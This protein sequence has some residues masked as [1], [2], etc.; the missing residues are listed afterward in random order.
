MSSLAEDLKRDVVRREIF[1]DAVPDYAKLRG[2]EIGALCSP[3]LKKCETEVFYYDVLPKEELLAQFGSSYQGRTFVDV[4][5]VAGTQ[6]LSAVLGEEKFDYFVA[7]HVIEHIPDFIGFFRAAFESLNPGGKF[8]LAMPDRRFTFDK[9]RPETSAGHLILDHENHGTVDAA[10]HFLDALIYHEAQPPVYWR[11]ME[12]LRYHFV[13]HHH[14]FNGKNFLDLVIRPLIRLGYFPFSVIRCETRPELY[15]EFVIVLE[16][17]D[18]SEGVSVLGE[19]IAVQPPAAVTPED[20]YDFR[21]QLSVIARSGLFDP[22]WYLTRYPSVRLAGLD[23][24]KHYFF[25]GGFNG[26]DPSPGFQ[27]AYY[28]QKNPDVKTSGWNPLWHYLNRGQKEG[29][30]PHP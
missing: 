25:Q 17:G 20:E 9:M 7:N 21:V 27:S 6:S 13:H 2:L 14:V 18:V 11:D 1:M 23:P 5:F 29:R 16:K 10:E 19:A 24:L 3:M 30:R 28:L 26:F 12:S 15:N 8:F 22:V 4:D